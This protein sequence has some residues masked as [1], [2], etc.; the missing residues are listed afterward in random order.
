[1]LKCLFGQLVD[2]Y[3]PATPDPAAATSASASCAP[4]ECGDPAAG[5]EAASSCGGDAGAGR[6]TWS[7]EMA[8]LQV[9]VTG[10]TML[11]LCSRTRPQTSTCF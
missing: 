5:D 7:A 2:E 9:G 4:S 6:V 11:D 1:M 3:G 10:V 8:F